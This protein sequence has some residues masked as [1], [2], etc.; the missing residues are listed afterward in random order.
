MIVNA[1]YRHLWDGKTIYCGLLQDPEKLHKVRL[2]KYSVV[3]H[4]A[5]MGEEEMHWGGGE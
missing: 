5:E 3:E 2:V 1:E 4:E